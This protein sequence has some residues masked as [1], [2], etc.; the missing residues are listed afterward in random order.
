MKLYIAIGEQLSKVTKL[1]AVA[2]HAT[3]GQLFH[4]QMLLHLK[5]MAVF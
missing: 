1:S 5:G 2:L 3:Q 4:L